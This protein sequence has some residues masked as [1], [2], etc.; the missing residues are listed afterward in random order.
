MV[1]TRKRTYGRR[2]VYRKR[3]NPQRRFIRRIAQKVVDK[4][5]ETK[6]KDLTISGT[7]SSTTFYGV[8]FNLPSQI[9]VG[10]GFDNRVG[11]RIKLLGYRYHLQVSPGDN[12]NVFRLLMVSRRDC[13]DIASTSAV[14]SLLGPINTDIFYAHKDVIAETRF[15]PVAG[16]TA[17]TVGIKRFY[18]GYVKLNRYIEYS[19]A[20]S[21]PTKGISIGMQFHSDSAIIPHP[22][23]EG[24][25]RVYYK[26]A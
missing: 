17:D 18:K 21:Y 15:A 14:T 25:I 1:Y 3:Y 26:D 7:A 10:S 20:A 19:G 2:T 8:H 13:Q 5:V 12:F 11:N 4:N 6:Y 23:V 9:P 16:S 24:Y 22:G